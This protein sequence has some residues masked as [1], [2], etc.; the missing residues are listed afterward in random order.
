V[1][2]VDDLIA[3]N[4]RANAEQY[5]RFITEQAAINNALGAS[6]CGAFTIWNEVN[7]RCEFSLL[8]SG[9]GAGLVIG[10]IVILALLSYLKR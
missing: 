6:E 7:Q 3:A 8:T 9:S 2:T 1:E 4:A 10:G 5:R